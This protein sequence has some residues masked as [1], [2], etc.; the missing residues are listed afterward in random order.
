MTGE[1][2]LLEAIRADPAEKLAWA[3]LADALEEQGA[4]ARA[5]LLR[6][7]LRMQQ[8]AEGEP[9]RACLRRVNELLAAGVRPCWPSLT[10]SLGIRFALVPPATFH[11]GSPLDE[12]DRGSDEPKGRKVTIPAP[13]Y[14]GIHPVTQAQFERIMGSNP[15]HH[16]RTG[17]ASASV[18]GM[19]TGDFPVESATWSEAVTFCKKLTA[20]SEE[21]Q[22][23]RTYRLPTEAEWEYACRGGPISRD[24][25]PFHF[26]DSLSSTQANFNG[27]QPY[28]GAPQGPYLGR[29][30]PVGSY[31]PNAWGLFDMH[32][33]VAEWCEDWRAR[34]TATR[35]N[36]RRRALRG[37]SWQYRGR[38]CRSAN[39]DG[40][41][42]GGRNSVV[43]FRALCEVAPAPT[44]RR[45][46]RR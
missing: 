19:D 20:L 23:G 14:L 10:N 44:R 7:V 24:A 4:D 25:P 27:N 13:F 30:C 1:Q 8:G 39:R 37:G 45:A 36:Q 21:K 35:P 12:D 42:P 34:P 41:S 29:T 28:G 5:E 18:A 38:G 9:L 22:A 6:L 31:P 40:M 11:L 16:S 32:G 26:G 46:A 15:S 33:N 3:A 17:G 43:G 2:A